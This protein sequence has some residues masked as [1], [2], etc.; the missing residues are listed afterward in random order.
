M[1]KFMSKVLK[2]EDCWYWKGGHDRYGYGRYLKAGKLVAVHREMYERTYG[3]IPEGNVIRH[4]CDN[5][6]CCNPEHLLAGTQADNMKD[7]VSRGRTPRVLG[8][9]K[10]S[11]EVKESIRNDGRWIPEL[12]KAYG[13]SQKLIVAILNE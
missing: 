3:P 6:G 12:S 7:K 5:P 4:K 10:V 1:D 11:A 13:L 2:E 8:L 9:R